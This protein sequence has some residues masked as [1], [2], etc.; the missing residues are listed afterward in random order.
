MSI[1]VCAISAAAISDDNHSAFAFTDD[2]EVSL[3]ISSSKV[4][5]LNQSLLLVHTAAAMQGNAA[6]G[7]AEA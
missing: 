5:Y 4:E 2:S 7:R 6:G 3:T 1:L